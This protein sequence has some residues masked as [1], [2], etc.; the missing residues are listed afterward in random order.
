[1]RAAVV[2][3]RLFAALALLTLIAG[4]AA[5]PYAAAGEPGAVPFLQVRIDRITPDVVTTTSEPTVTVSGSI[6]N[7][8]DR[9]VRDVMVRLEH[10]GA[11][12]SSAG[13][14]TNLTGNV[15]QYESVADFITVAPELPRGQDVPFNLVY[16]L[17]SAEL[18]SLNIAEPGVYPLMVNVNGTPD[19]G[20]PARLDDARFLLPVLGVPP[21]PA[22]DSAADTLTSVV[23]PDTSKPVRLTMLWPLAD[24]PRLAAGAP[25][26]TTPVRLIDD[27][28]ATSL[29]AGGRLDILLS[30]VD[31]ATSPPVDPGGE[32]RNAMCLAVDPDL[33]VTVNAMAGGYVVNDAPDAGPGTPT[34]PGA[35]QDAAIGWLNRLKALGQRLCVTPTTYSQA[36]LDALQRVG[37]PG[38]NTVATKG[39]ADIIDQILGVSSIRGATLVGD[40]PLTGP[41]VE[42]LSAQGPTVAIA[43]ANFA[44]HDSAT[45]EPATADVRPL[46]YTPHLVAAPFDASVGAALAGAGTAPASPS[47]L[48]P[49]LDIPVKHDSAVARRQDALGSLLWRG[50]HPDTEPRTQILS[51]PLAWNLQ[52]DDAQAILTAVASTIHAGLAVA[53]PLSAVIA[54]ANAAAP[55]DL[56]PLPDGAMGNPR[57]R[58]DDGVVS[59]ISSVTGRLWA[60]GSALT[61][62]A[63][64]GLTGAQYTAPLREDLLRALSQ[65]VP[66]D[67]RNG[68]AQQRLTTV[69]HTVDDLFGAVSIVN[70]GGSYTLATEHSPL[71]LALR[72]DLPVPIRVRLVIDAPPGMSV[73]DMGEIEL[74]PGYLPLKVPIEVHFTQRVAVDVALRTAD[75]LPLGEPV[76]LSVHSN[77][78]GK[79]LFFITLTGG[80]VLAL[81]VGRRLWHRFRGQPDRAD[82]DRPDPIDVAMAY[83]NDADASP[84]AMSRSA[85]EEQ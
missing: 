11:V 4:P 45:G 73:T 35:G 76:R 10:A 6:L 40:G 56:A 63:R 26:G 22:A 77:A 13:L 44:A 21:E 17:R 37:D 33:L 65:S 5:A 66:P 68:L 41:A 50:L 64:T 32:V 48:D 30:A 78:Y 85:G 24:R 54:E 70:P 15:D 81:L 75:G 46:R 2:L 59:G 72:N 42:M 18:S 29:A 1:V 83:G 14:R 58:F 69:G 7:V 34:H 47:Y 79:V 27:D 51:P 49:S 36:D 71:P 28:L 38:L 8:G 60:L 31:F 82:L 53:R 25:G 9:P 12:T 23:P 57:G 80:A 74:P 61:T 84:P 16:P 43:G 39:A 67:A 52:P 20:E 55:Q 19:Y 3:A 62:D